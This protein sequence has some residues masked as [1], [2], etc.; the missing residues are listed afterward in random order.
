MSEQSSP[1]R[2]ACEAIG[3]HW[4]IYWPAWAIA[5]VLAGLLS[6]TLRSSEEQSESAKRCR[7]AGAVY[8]WTEGECVTGVREIHP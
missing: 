2:K 7:D 5:L 6:L 4:R 8:L 1:Y 3:W